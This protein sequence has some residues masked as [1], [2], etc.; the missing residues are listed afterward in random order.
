MSAE[1]GTTCVPVGLRNSPRA[2]H[3]FSF[4]GKCASEGKA[5]SV[6]VTQ[7][8]IEKH[9]ASEVANQINQC[10][11]A[12][13]YA[14]RITLASTC[15]SKVGSTPRAGWTSGRQTRGDLNAPARLSPGLDNSTGNS[16]ATRQA[17]R[18]VARQLLDRTPLTP[19]DG[20]V[21]CQARQLDSSTDLIRTRQTS[22]EP[23]RYGP[24]C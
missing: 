20:G 18:Q 24:A 19:C 22:T 7:K 1:S 16:T 17:T 11:P 21:K 23:S 3:S 9:R 14:N 4:C 15:C 10:M 6:D 8:L 12:T 13:D 2:I 5:V